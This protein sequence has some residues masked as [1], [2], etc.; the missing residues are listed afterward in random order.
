MAGHVRVF[1]EM[2]EVR[3]GC[4]LKREDGGALPPD[5][6]VAVVDHVGRHVQ[7]DFTHLVQ[8]C[9]TI[10]VVGQHRVCDA[11]HAGEG[12]SADEQVCALLV[13]ADLA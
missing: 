13:L 6:G 7:R 9:N 8:K 2:H 10:L 11:Y 3:L 12:Q 4:L 1:E 5:A